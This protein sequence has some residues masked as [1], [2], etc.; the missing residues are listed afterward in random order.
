MHGP[1]GSLLVN[2]YTFY[3]AFSAEEEFRV[4]AGNKT[5][6]SIPVSSAISVGDF[7]LFAAKTWRVDEVD[8]DSKSIFVTH[9]KTGKAP[10][11]NSTR[12]VVHDRV[13]E[14][15]RELY[16]Q[17]NEPSFLDAMA[18]QLLDEGRSTYCRFSLGKNVFVSAGNTHLL[19][20][21]LGDAKNEALAMMLRTRGLSVS[22]VGPALEIFGTENSA[23]DAAVHLKEI[24][25]MPAPSANMLLAEAHN[26]TQEKWDWTLPDRLLQNSFASLRLDI[27]GVHEWLK[28]QPIFAP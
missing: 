2:H 24:A 13:R 25:A 11:F 18:K 17:S 22:L 7:I 10:P 20:T 4:V 16:E 19:F 28:T 9:H 23:L 3:A 26:L 8:E 21:W 14:R 5:L 12:G 15:M 27:D 6:G 1:K